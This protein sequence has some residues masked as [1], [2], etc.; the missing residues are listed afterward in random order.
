M[1]GKNENANAEKS[2]RLVL[3]ILCEIEYG[4]NVFN[5]I[6]HYFLSRTFLLFELFLILR[7]ET[8]EVPRIFVSGLAKYIF[9]MGTSTSDYYHMVWSLY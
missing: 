4:T 5:K 3:S 2:S 7:G 9:G 1:L 6:W 8:S